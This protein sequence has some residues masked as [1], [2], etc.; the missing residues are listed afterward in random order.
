MTTILPLSYHQRLNIHIP[1]GWQPAANAGERRLTSTGIFP[2][3]FR[4]RF[5]AY[6]RRKDS[7]LCGWFMGDL[8]LIYGWIMADLWVIYGVL[9]MIYGWF[10]GDL[11]CFMDDLWVFYGWFM[12]DLWM[13]YGWFM[14]ELW[15]FDGG[16]KGDFYIVAKQWHLFLVIGFRPS[17]RP[18][19]ILTTRYLM[20]IP[21]APWCW[22]IYL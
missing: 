12:G 20:I 11:W 21:Y 16:F 9:W 6:L 1:T 19:D 14:D 13:I 3:L 15:V 10:M 4:T 22:F 18:T 5:R 8:W 2:W 7:Q 17:L